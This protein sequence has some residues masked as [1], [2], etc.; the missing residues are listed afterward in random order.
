MTTTNLTNTKPAI[1][2][3]GGKAKLT[4]Y[5]LPHIPEHNC[6]VEVFG[7]GLALMLA[8]PRSKMEVANDF[9]HDLVSFYRVVKWHCDE[10][11]RELEFM[12]NSR[13]DFEDFIAQPGLTEIQRVARWYVRNAISFGGMG[14]YFGT[15]KKSGGVQRE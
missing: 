13:K 6:Y 14:S 7:G 11:L 5:L 15:S 4:K 12:T 1:R 3:P 10:L 2:W 8:K 9:N